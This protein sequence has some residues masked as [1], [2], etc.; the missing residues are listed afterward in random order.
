MKQ[1]LL[2]IAALLASNT[3]HADCSYKGQAY[4]E[5]AEVCGAGGSL[6][7]CEQG[8]WSL[9]VR[10]CAEAKATPGSKKAKRSRSK[11]RNTAT[12]Y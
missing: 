9:T 6:Q 11:R 3:A 10:K 7:R 2:I 5:G 4:S 1:G 12:A 8:Q